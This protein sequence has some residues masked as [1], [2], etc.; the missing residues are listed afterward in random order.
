MKKYEKE[1]YLVPFR[2]CAHYLDE[3]IIEGISLS[4]YGRSSEQ[5]CIQRDIAFQSHLD[6]KSTCTG[7]ENIFWKTGDNLMQKQPGWELTM[8]GA[9]YVLE[10]GKLFNE[11]TVQTFS[12]FTYRR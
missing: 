2:A 1:R 11:Q 6:V 4:W 8:R 3:L 7:T 9:E 5:R 10:L 12:K